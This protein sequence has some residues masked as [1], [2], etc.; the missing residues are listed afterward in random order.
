MNR[1]SVCQMFGTNPRKTYVDGR[2]YVRD[3][4]GRWYLGAPKQKSRTRDRR[5]AALVTAFIVFPVYGK[6]LLK[7]LRRQTRLQVRR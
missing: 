4:R 1:E 7:Q 2:L 6:P 5:T 3:L